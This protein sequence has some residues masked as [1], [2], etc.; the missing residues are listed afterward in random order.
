M[1]LI[2]LNIWGGHEFDALTSFIRAHAENTDVFCFQEVFS[3]PQSM[4]SRGARVNIFEELKNILPHHRAFFAPIQDGMDV[5]GR[6]DIHSTFGQAIFLDENLQV[7]E[8]GFAFT[9]RMRNGMEGDDITT[10]P[11]GFQH[12]RVKAGDTPLTVV[13]VH[14]LSRPG[15]KLD[16]SD[17]LA[18][19]EKIKDF[20]SKTDGRKII[21]GDFNLMP[22]TESITMLEENMKNLIKEFHVTDTRGE[23]NRQQYPNDPTP[24]YFADYC[25]VSPDINVESFQVPNVLASDHLPLILEFS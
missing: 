18:Q 7:E 4:V 10:L 19:S 6:V 5:E 14:G 22:E 24:Q 20:L 13:G 9:Y 8:E 1:K 25:F 23:L 12:I 16:T 17:R 21:C 3:S 11:T 2:S 15:D